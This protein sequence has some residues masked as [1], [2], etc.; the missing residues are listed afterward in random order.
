VASDRGGITRPP[1]VVIRR[2]PHSS[3]HRHP[4]IHSYLVA[5]PGRR[6]VVRILEKEGVDLR[7]VYIGHSNA[8]TAWTTRRSC[9]TKVCT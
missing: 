3:T 9:W 7:R 6:V 2:G 5:R 8:D 1:E 4:H